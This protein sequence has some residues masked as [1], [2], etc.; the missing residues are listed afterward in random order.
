MNE[1]TVNQNEQKVVTTYE[2]NEKIL[3]V[4]ESTGLNWSVIQIPLVTLSDDPDINGLKSGSTGIFRK[5]TKQWLGSVTDKYIP[6]QNSQLAETLVLASEG[7][8]LDVSRGGMLHEGKKVYLQCELKTEFIGKSSVRRHITALNSHNGST[9]I[10]FGS[11]NTVVVCENTFYKA[12]RDIPKFRHS[13]SAVERIKLAMQELRRTIVMDEKLMKNFK[14][15]SDTPLRDEIFASILKECFDINL[16]AK[17][18]DI[19]GNKL[20]VAEKVNLAMKTEMELEGATLWGLFN[21]VTRYTNH[22]TNTKQKTEFI[23]T[24][25]GYHINLIAY[26]TIMDWIGKNTKQEIEIVN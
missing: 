7:I 24:G 12:Y 2:Q 22:S 8:G 15:M 6:Y 18:G 13:E 26:N 17:K 5:D 20:K 9:S 4:L 3:D 19:N 23:M 25:R 1:A 11:S 10:G 16:D 21:G 14:I